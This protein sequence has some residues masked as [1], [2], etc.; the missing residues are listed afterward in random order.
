M[1][2]SV[3]FA[4]MKPG[5]PSPDPL[6]LTNRTIWQRVK[7]GL[8]FGLPCIFL[9]YVMALALDG[10]F[11]K[12]TPIPKMDP[13]P[14]ELAAKTLPNLDHVKVESNRDIDILEVHIDRADGTVLAG[15]VVNMTG[16]PLETAE[17]VF[18]LS[19]GFGAHLGGVTERLENLEPQKPH[20]F[21]MAIDH[22]DARFAMVS[23]VRTK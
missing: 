22:K 18:D 11:V 9:F 1:I 23:E 5:A 21:R 16:R 4:G 12:P 14:A 17:I 15:T 13:A 2:E 10:Y 7:L 6:Y 8:L 19:D 20:R 3:V